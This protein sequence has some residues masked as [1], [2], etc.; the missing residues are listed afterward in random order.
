MSVIPSKDGLDLRTVFAQGDLLA[1]PLDAVA[2]DHRRS[3]SRRSVAQGDGTHLHHLAR[4]L[5]FFLVE[6][7]NAIWNNFDKLV[8]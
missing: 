8:R 6:L 4:L 5:S 2:S 7:G 1:K 3:L